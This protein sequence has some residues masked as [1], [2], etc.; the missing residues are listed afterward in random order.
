VGATRRE[1]IFCGEAAVAEKNPKCRRS[2]VKA[3]W[4]L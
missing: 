4:A 1:K 3:I 2:L